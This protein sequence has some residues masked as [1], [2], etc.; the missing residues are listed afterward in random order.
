[1]AVQLTRKSV[2]CAPSVS[3]HGD[4]DEPRGA[5]LG[6]T[7]VRGLGAA[8]P[9]PDIRIGLGFR[10][11]SG[12][13]LRQA[14]RAQYP[15]YERIIGNASTNGLDIESNNTLQKFRELFRT[16]ET[17]FVRDGRKLTP[18]ITQEDGGQQQP[19]TDDE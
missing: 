9:I 8:V 10:H 13:D 18:V 19:R 17:K 14:E 7:R 15:T 2:Q 6:Q 3:V 12:V 1:M 5:M 11:A 4:G 16:I